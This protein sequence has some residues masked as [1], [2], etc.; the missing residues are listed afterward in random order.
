MWPFSSQE[1][2]VKA[3]Q[4][5]FYDTIYMYGGEMEVVQVHRLVRNVS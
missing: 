2:H 1:K 4:E 3:G 5:L